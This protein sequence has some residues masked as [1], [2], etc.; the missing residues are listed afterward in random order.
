MDKNTNYNH[1]LKK[2]RHGNM[3]LLFFCLST[4]LLI[5]CVFL[6]FTVRHWNTECRN[7]RS[8][9]YPETYC[10]NHNLYCEAFDPE[11]YVSEQTVSWTGIY[12]TI[13][14]PVKGD[15]KQVGICYGNC[16]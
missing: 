2:N 14:F 4:I 9:G 8:D 12:E 11:T 7:S 10:Y 16:F 6:L 15:I 13:S 3:F 5:V 1:Q